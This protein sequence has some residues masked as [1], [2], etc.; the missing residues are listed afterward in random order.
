MTET[1]KPLPPDAEFIGKLIAEMKVS[2]R[3]VRSY[4]GDHPVVKNALQRVYTALQ[5]IFHRR[6]E[7]TLAIGRD[8]FIVDEHILCK[9]NHLYRQ[10]AQQ[11]R[12]MGIAYIHFSPGLTV[13][14]LYNCCHFMSVQSKDL[15]SQNIIDI[16]NAYHLSHINVGF[17]DYEA[18]SFEEGKTA[19]E[20][21]QEDLWETY[22]TGIING[23]LS[24]EEL[25]E[26]IED[27]SLD[28]FVHLLGGLENRGIDRTSSQKIVSLYVK[29]YFQ[30][31]LSNKEIRKL[32]A[33]IEALPS[34][35]QEQFLSAVIE[36]LSKDILITSKVLQNLSAELIM[37]LFDAIQSK[38]IDIPENLRN[39][40]DVVLNFE[41]HTVEQRIIGDN[42]LVDDIFLPSHIV[43]GHIPLESD[44]KNVL[45]DSF[46]TSASDE[47]QKE[48]KRML[49]FDAME[50]ISISLPELKREIDD[51]FIQKTFNHIILEIMASDIVSQ[52]EYVQYI[53]NLK[54]QATQFIVTGQYEQVLRIKRFLQLNIEKGKFADIT[55]EALKYYSTSEFC[56]AFIDSLKII[57]RQ[58]RDQAWLL[59]E[60]YGETI[61]PFLLNAL[62]NEETKSSRSL[63]MSLIRQFGDLIIPETLRLLDDSRWFVK[64]NMLYLLHGSKNKDL[65]PHV[66]PYSEHENPKVSF[67]AIKC[68]LSLEEKSVVEKLSEYLRSGTEEEIAQAITLL[69]AY[70]VEE[71]VSELVQM[72]RKRGKSKSA[73][74]QK[75]AIIQ[76]LG[77]IGDVRA[78][79]ALREILFR[80]K[81]FLLTNEKEPLKVEIY[82]SMKNYPRKAIED[83]IQKGLKSRNEYIKNESLRLTKMKEQ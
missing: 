82:K 16:F 39:L 57:G 25:S 64:R 6:K 49:D 46:E 70:R 22:I 74:S 55:A 43:T 44:A 71:A 26:Q 38:K 75:I 66:R 54:E 14:E 41:S 1:T 8:A 30:K 18:F 63:L 9:D 50:R 35:L 72:L 61:I 17:L 59:C 51:D 77:D 47:Y 19:I 32:L 58:T 78:L 15:S 29:K 62:I 3:I 56:T 24:I 20:I 68:L 81:F 23:T 2:S 60:N 28:T 40:L 10:M 53:E 33:F 80:K 67:E 69:G 12:R 5:E 73:L 52:T 13:D 7:I 42:L 45:S 34:N 83:I 37:D 31:A 11:L 21:P 4:P 27:A 48:I 76:T 65:I 36:T 79:D